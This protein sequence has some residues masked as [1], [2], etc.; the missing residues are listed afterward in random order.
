MHVVTI[1]TIIAIVI[2]PL[3]IITTR[4]LTTTTTL[5]S[6]A[7]TTTTTTHV[8]VHPV[9]HRILTALA[10]QRVLRHRHWI[11]HV[12]GRQPHRH[13]WILIWRNHI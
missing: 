2:I 4:T 10:V 13:V 8:P 6:L 7:T 12:L 9:S 1:A 3:T 5:S 11:V